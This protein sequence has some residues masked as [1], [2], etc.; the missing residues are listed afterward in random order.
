MNQLRLVPSGGRFARWAGLT[1]LA[2]ILA[3]RLALGLAYS[4]VVPAWESY[5]EDGHFA[6]ARYL[7]VNRTWLLAPGDPEAEKIWERFQPPLYYNLI[8]P[9]I[10]G[11]NLGEAF[12]GPARNPHFTA[13]DAGVNYALHPRTVTEAERQLILGV[14]AARAVSVLIST[15]SVIAMWAA[16]RR[17]WPGERWMVLTA[18]ALYAFWPQF[19]F[20]G[21]MV[22]NDALVTALAAAALVPIAGLIRHGF[23]LRRALA[24]G[25]WTGAA[26]LAKINAASLV[27]VAG[28][29]LGLSLLPLEG[30]ARRWRPWQIILVVGALGLGLAGAVWALSSLEFV[31]GQVF[32][33]ATVREFVRNVGPGGGSARSLAAAALPYAFR[34]FVASFGWGN[35]ETFGWVYWLWSAGAG[36]AAAGLALGVF[37][38]R[39]AGRQAGLYAVMGIFVISLLGLT[40]ALAVAHQSVY[41]VPGRYLLPTLPAVVILLVGGWREW[42]PRG[43]AG[44]WIART[45]SAG[46]ALLGWAIAVGTLLPVYAAPPPMTAA[47]ARVDTAQAVFFDERIELVGY[48]GPGTVRAG[49]AMTVT[50]CWQAVAPIPEDYSLFLEVV[51]ADQQGYGRLTTYPGRGNYPTSA[52]AVNAPFCETY[53]IGLGTA[54]PA[55]ALAQLQVSWLDDATGERLPAATFAGDRLKEG[56]TQIAFKV[57]AP[58]GY[59]PPAANEV[60]FGFGGSGQYPNLRLTG[61]AV[62]QEDEEIIITLRW[63]ALTAIPGDYS[64]FVHLRDTPETFYALGDS[65]PRGGAYPTW[66][67]QPGEIVQ[68]THRL[69]LDGL[70]TPPLALYVGLHN[71][72]EEARVA[73]YAEDW[74][75]LDHDEVLLAEG[76]QFR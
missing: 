5:D 62:E 2:I 64:V 57:S 28:A 37:R 46:A 75:R 19:L 70:P 20:V 45:A 1:P 7:A 44:R 26:L 71:P 63:E 33:L 53:T 74:S 8:A 29:A 24:L 14:R 73:A 50:L 67:W 3:T 47:T 41:L 9:V 52:W 55:P 18:T 4:Q 35:V 6:Y 49:E 69:R 48:S 65:Q 58:P 15:L 56:L 12:D 30:Q 38:R 54:I 76:L 31:T 34:T 23:R 51:G 13:G 40:L 21:S 60:N 11:F 25:A 22:T 17:V 16:A 32:Q 42:I 59:Q 27:P 10:A 68:D 72:A 61:Y 39:I 66:M 43:A 36:V